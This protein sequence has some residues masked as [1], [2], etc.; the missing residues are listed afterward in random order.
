MKH[1]STVIVK[2]KRLE[3]SDYNLTD[4]AAKYLGEGLKHSNCKLESLYL[5]GNNFTDSAAK[6]LGEAQ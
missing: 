6:D 2:L 1:L 5:S 3:F 4:N